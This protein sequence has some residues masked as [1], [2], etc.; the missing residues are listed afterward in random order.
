MPKTRL[1]AK[2]CSTPTQKSPVVEGTASVAQQPPVCHPEDL[3]KNLGNA[4]CRDF[5]RH[6]DECSSVS[7]SDSDQDDLPDALFSSEASSAMP[8]KGDPIWVK[9]RNHT[10]WPSLVLHSNPRTRKIQII[11]L[12]DASGNG[13]RL[14][15]KVYLKYNK[16]KVL[17]YNHED[18]SKFEAAGKSL[19]S[20]ELRKGFQGALAE[21]V[22]YMT[23][24]ALGNTASCKVF[25]DEPPSSEDEEETQESAPDA[26]SADPPPVT[27]VP[28]KTPTNPS[29]RKKSR[30]EETEEE[31]SNGDVSEKKKKVMT[32]AERRAMRKEKNQPLVD[33][34]CSREMKEHLIKIY[35]GETVSERHSL[36]KQGHTQQRK[37]QTNS[38]G[39]IDDEDQ[40][41]T[42][43][44]FIGDCYLEMSQQKLPN[45]DYLLWVMLPE[46]I[47][48]AL[49]K[50]KRCGRKKAAELFEKGIKLTKCEHLEIHHQLIRK[51]P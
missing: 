16:K 44:D 33:F 11:F 31:S 9:H 24:R 49:S 42:V 30:D 23:K 27:P 4:N 26:P 25:L 12:D 20:P 51:T 29:K 19:E 10:F 43:V 48:Y 47:I 37:I 40:L 35:R 38:S 15:S 14:R 17:P 45:M 5:N 32:P 8:V 34:I 21:M 18:R 7:D 36:F 2:L 50:L 6:Q 13:Q 22:D 46:A 1:T 39:P 28:S 3:Y 41:E